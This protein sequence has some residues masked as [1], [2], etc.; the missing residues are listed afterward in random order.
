MKRPDRIRSWTSGML[1]LFAPDYVWHPLAQVWQQEGPGET[2]VAELFGGTLEQKMAVVTGMGMTG[3]AAERVAAGFGETMGRAVLSLLRSA[4]Q[5]VMAGA[6]Q[7]LTRARRRPGLA[8]VATA[9]PN[10][11]PEMHR[12][13]AH[14][15]GA[16]IAVLDGVGHW[17]PVQDP[18]PAVEAMTRFWAGLPG[19]QPPALST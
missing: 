8:L 10:G 6:G 18:R 16:D 7:G 3:L 17:W 2:S 11:N 12:W 15:A 13:A 14:Q 19:R 9:D 5:P 4:V 1:Q